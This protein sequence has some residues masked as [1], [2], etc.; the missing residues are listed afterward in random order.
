[1]GILDLFRRNA[2]RVER[3]AS[4]FG[5]DVARN[6][7]GQAVW[8]RRNLEQYS[9]EGYQQNAIVYRCV[10]LIAENAAS[11]KIAAKRGERELNDRDPLLAALRAPSP[12]HS[13]RALLTAAYS[14]RL[15]TGN[16]FLEAV[17]VGSSV[18]ELHTH[19]PERFRVIPG[20][21]GYPQGYEFSVNGAQR[22]ITIEPARPIILHLKDFHPLDDWY[23]MS[24]LDP[25][26]WALDGH[27]YGSRE[28]ATTLSK[29]GVPIGG[30]QHDGEEPLTGEQIGQARESFIERLLQARRDRYPLVVDK[31][32]TWLKF[33]LGPKELGVT[34]LKADAAREICFALGVPPMLL[35]IPGD[36]TYANYAEANRAFWRETVIPFARGNLEEIGNWLGRLQ[37]AP[38]LML[39]PDTDGIPALASERRE[40]SDMMN[41]AEFVT[42]NE[43]RE[44]LGFE[45]VEGGDVVLVASS[46]I[47]LSDAG[48]TIAGGAEPNPSETA[49]VTDEEPDPDE[50][51]AEGS[52]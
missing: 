31:K 29:G 20:A 28:V 1:M 43:K 22:R 3:K 48:A 24:P 10:R 50:D 5:P 46:D 18:A 42:V 25:A 37:G 21:D 30:F 12:F 26:A 45:P 32:W 38:D 23:G 51:E 40:L 14:F 9:R 39:E 34:E 36:N 15:L 47:P 44:A 19:R 16:A 8:T 49:D 4:A 6:F 52:A 13:G 2:P 17:L 41:A 27:T 33:G 35:G 7:V 11:L